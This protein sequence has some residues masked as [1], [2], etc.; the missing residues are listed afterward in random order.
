M[1]WSTS[2]RKG[3]LPAN[4]DAIRTRVK[5]RARGRCEAPRHVAE[6]DGIGKHCDHV[7][8]GDDHSLANLQWLSKP[9]HDAKTR[10]EAAEAHGITRAG[11]LPT[12][13]HPGKVGGSTPYPLGVSDCG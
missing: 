12:E 6:C 7:D 13:D 2:D 5:S 3:R 8:R 10:V 4:W 1:S 11:R 9:C